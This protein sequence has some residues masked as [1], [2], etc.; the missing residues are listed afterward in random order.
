MDATQMER[1]SFEDCYSRLEEVIDKLEQGDL[2]VE[3][4]VALYEEGMQLAQRC[5]R[6]LNDA[7]LRVSQLLSAGATQVEE[8]FLYDEE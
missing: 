7:E 4:S 3:E 5:D 6:E 1:L 8:E 2:S